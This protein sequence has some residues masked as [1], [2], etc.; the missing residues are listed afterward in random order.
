MKRTVLFLILALSALGA[1]AQNISVSS[2]RDLTTDM[3]ASSLEGKRIDQNNEACALIKIVTTQTGFTF[4]AG[5]LGI[6]DTKQEAGEVWVW[7]PRGSRKITIKH[8]QLGVLREYRYPIEIMPERTYEMVLV[9]GTVETIVKEQVREQYLMFQITPADA[10]LEVDDQV[11]KVSN[12]GTARKLVDFGT[13]TYRVQAP[14]YHPE[15]GQVTVNDPNSTQKVNVTLKPNFGWIEVPSSG[16]LNGAVVYVDNA[17]IGKVPCKSGPLKSGQHNVKIAKELYETYNQ[18]VTVRDNETTQVTPTLTANFA[19]VTLQVDAD[20][21]IWVNDERKGVRSWSGDLESGSYKIECKMDNHE[22]TSVKKEITSQMNGDVI[23]LNAPLPIYGSLVVE[24]TPDMAEL[25]IDG[26][27]YGET[28]KLIP[29]ILIGQHDI[30]LSKS[31]YGDFTSR[32]V[33]KKGERCQVEATLNNGKEIQFTC[34]VSTAQLEIDGQRVGSASGT[35]MLTY[36]QHTLKA[37]ADNFVDYTATLNVTESSRSHSIKLNSKGQG[38]IGQFFPLYGVTLG[39]TTWKE[40]ENMGGVLKTASSGHG[41]YAD[42]NKISFWDHDEL[43]IF[44]SLYWTHYDGAFPDSWKRLGFSWDNSYNDWLATFRRLGYTITIK[45]EPKT[46][47]YSGRKTLSA[48]FNALSPDGVL[49]FRLN[50]SYGNNN[51]DGF[52][53]SSPRS[54]YGITVD[55]MNEVTKVSQSSPSQSTP[56]QTT[57]T[58]T[59]Q[60]ISSSAVTQFFPLHGITL[61]Q[62]TWKDAENLGYKVEMF[63][64]GP[65]RTAKKNEV[66]RGTFWDH[67]GEGVFTSIYWT[68]YSGTFPESWKRLGFS[69]DNS[70]NDW[71]K[72]FKQLGYTVTIKNA[73]VTKDYRGRNTLSADVDALSPDGTLEFRLD[74]DYGNNNNDGYSESSPRSLYGI[75]I[76]YKGTAGTVSRS[77]SSRS[78][79]TQSTPTQNSQTTSSGSINQFFPLFGITIGKTTWKEA[80]DLGNEVKIWEKGPARHFRSHNVAFWDHKG[81]GVFKDVHWTYSNGKFP[82]S[83]KQLGFSWDNSYNDWLTTFRRLG[84]TITIKEEPKTKTWQGRKTLSAEFKAVSPDGALEFRL[85]FDYGNKN[86]EGYQ[87]S[88]PNSLY[89]LDIKYKK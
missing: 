12:E 75:T 21:E 62:T 39:Q 10:I 16:S 44:T 32:I 68:H 49:E 43:G 55:Y 35:Y 52:K 63:E 85:D 87:V 5:A 48:R 73:P 78:T 51:K 9:T 31:G 69:W 42:I 40:A 57:P 84:Y 17:M 53:E 64:K 54:L 81:E 71:L 66:F 65:D 13:Y 60:T 70:Y 23:R 29:E 82:E 28:P 8:P 59:T 72:T 74:F 47:I 33:V 25:F 2:F 37:T 79:P 88:S 22:S 7:V 36:G 15:A 3:T 46:E 58:Q 11:W 34:N 86:K 19:H 61:G 83:W 6:V 67:K 41:Q 24:S 4:E 56:T 14:N 45:E 26:K 77:N 38:T 30:R 80:E 20:A 89:S 18:V 1:A 50:F 76:E 27:S